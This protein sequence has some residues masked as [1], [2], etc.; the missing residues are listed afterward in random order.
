MRPRLILITGAVV[1]LLAWVGPLPAMVPESF[2]AHMAL[3]MLAV[4]VAAPLLAAG[5]APM[6]QSRRWPLL[7]PIAASLF[8]LVVVWIWH[9]PALHHLSRT[10]PIA[11]ALEQASFLGVALLVWIVALAGPPLAGALTLFF[12]SMHMTLLG[13]LLSLAPR[14]IYPGHSHGGWL[15]A[16][17]DQQ[18]GGAIMLGVGSV[19]YLGGGLL[20]T[21]RVL[22][23]AQGI[24]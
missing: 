5:V 22:R 3:H 24:G 11:L 4:G 21:A 13:T 9:T 12:T 16:L 20:L 7:L 1:L 15:D 6:L 23:P 17:P 14:P 2:A 10:D 8:D 18:L 19:I